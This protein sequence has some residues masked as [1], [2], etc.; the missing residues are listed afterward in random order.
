MDELLASKV[1]SH[2]QQI[3]VDHI[4]PTSESSKANADRPF[5]GSET[6]VEFVD[7][8]IDAVQHALAAVETFTANILSRLRYRRNQ[9]SAT[10]RRLPTEL[11]SL[12]FEW[13]E[14]SS[15]S[16]YDH[17]RP[18]TA[19]ILSGVSKLWRE[20]ALNTPRL[21]TD[22]RLALDQLSK[23]QLERSKSAPL[24]ITIV[25]G[26]SNITL[27]SSTTPPPHIDRWQ[28]LTLFPREDVRAPPDEVVAWLQHSAPRLRA[29]D[30][31]VYSSDPVVN[32]DIG[33]FDFDTE[34]F[35]G[36]APLVHELSLAG[37]YVPFTLPIYT[38]LTKLRLYRL[39]FSTDLT[40]YQ[41]LAALA[42]SPL[43]EEL[44]I[45]QITTFDDSGIGDPP[46]SLSL[47]IHLSHLNSLFL[48]SMS[49]SLMKYILRS[50]TIPPTSY[51]NLQLSHPRVT[52]SL[53]DVFP[54]SPYNLRNLEDVCLLTFVTR[55]KG[56]C[57]A[58]GYNRDKKALLTITAEGSVGNDCVERIFNSLGESLSIMPVQMVVIC[59]YSK[60][61]WSGMGFV[62]TL[63]H[64]DT[65]EALFLGACHPKFLAQLVSFPNNH[66]C[67]RLRSLGI[68]NC[69]IS[70]HLL[71]SIVRSRNPLGETK[72]SPDRVRLD[73]LVIANC[74]NITRPTLMDLWEQI[75]L[76]AWYQEGQSTRFLDVGG[77]KEGSEENDGVTFLLR[78]MAMLP[79][80]I[81]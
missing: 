32:A 66:P 2:L 24:D 28:S 34:I 77:Y 49:T 68:F 46:L 50:V 29:L 3:L 57:Q 74:P 61:R 43:L 73:S 16:S 70:E 55:P 51:L 63:S 79:A 41:M 4:C 39:V 38:G 72:P 25:T 33:D 47:D 42:T 35:K 36:G 13:A 21:W 45:T 59:A 10:H 17:P 6:T 65:L 30:V 54:R 19:L 67:P 37:L 58:D 62:H 9:L 11:L 76:I 60:R 18:N 80:V 52:E 7:K 12:V 31:W 8:E 15:R 23:I 71:R 64:F 5:S 1:V 27:P 22:I 26:R 44:S 56:G 78:C 69:P 14:R 40:P 53:L 48:G 81:F 20:V 75:G